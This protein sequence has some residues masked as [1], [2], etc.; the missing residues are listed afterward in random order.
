ML[1]GLSAKDTGEVYIQGNRVHI[2]SPLDAVGHRLAY[3]PEDRRNHGVILGM[4]V[5]ANTSIASLDKVS[6]AGFLDFHSEE[7]AAKNFASSLAL[8]PPNVR[9]HVSSFSGGNQQKVALSRWLMTRPKVLILDEPTQG[10]DV[11]A[12]SELFRLIGTLAEQGTA[13]LL[14]S[15]DMLEVLGMSDRVA[16]MAKG[17]IAGILNRSEATAYRVLELSLGHDAAGQA[18]L[19]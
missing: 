19:E 11:G 16:V 7:E 9:A 6:K 3:L 14:I 18:G 8:K 12:K 13:I 17:Q 10:I 2:Q 1:F 4:S 5:T 15:S